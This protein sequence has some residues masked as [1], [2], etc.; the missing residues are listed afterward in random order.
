MAMTTIA[1]HWLLLGL[2]SPSTPPPSAY[3]PENLYLVHANTAKVSEKVEGYQKV[4]LTITRVYLGPAE[5]KDKKFECLSGSRG[6]SG[7]SP[8][9]SPLSVITFAEEG[10]EG[11]WWV[12]HDK[13]A[14]VY[15]PELRWKVLNEWKIQS[16]PIQKHRS[17]WADFSGRP[18]DVEA[19][20]KE[21]LANWAVPAQAL[22]TAKSDDGRLK[23]LKRLAADPKAPAAPWA[24]SLIGRAGT[25]EALVALQELSRNE[26]I[27][28]KTQYALD[29]ALC[30]RD[31]SW[32]SSGS[33]KK[34]LQNWLNEANISVLATA[35]L[36]A[37]LADDQLD[38][39]TYIA[40]WEACFA[41]RD[42]YS[43]SQQEL[44]M[45]LIPGSS[46]R[47]VEDKPALFAFLTG[48]L[49][50]ADTGELQYHASN[51]LQ[52][53]RPLSENEK[54]VVRELRDKA[55]DLRAIE[56]LERLLK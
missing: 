31:A 48:L 17:Q 9:D 47:R 2:L 16:F 42:K 46:V 15:K 8:A 39:A 32:R 35:R 30:K 22:D 20:F 44:L 55:T 49:R 19:L 27:S 28:L 24:S 14:N 54:A 7:T 53:C 10:V 13:K 41:K 25:K 3:L 52:Y 6:V 4:Q 11:F 23:L 26:K 29:E 21:A 33:R 45:Q 36:S 51:R 12:Y 38:F 18:I 37:A 34:M 5:L 43:K 50:K 1:T 40:L 56:S